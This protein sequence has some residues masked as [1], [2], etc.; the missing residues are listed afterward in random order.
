MPAIDSS[1]GKKANPLGSCS[2]R[3]LVSIGWAATIEP[4]EGVD[5]HRRAPDWGLRGWKKRFAA[6]LGAIRF[7]VLAW[8]YER[9]V[10]MTGGIEL[11]VLAALL[12]RKTSLVAA[13]WLIP[14]S[15]AL[16]ALPLLRRV[17][18]VVVRRNDIATLRRRF[19]VANTAFVP[20][21]APPTGDS[22]DG[23]YVY[24]GG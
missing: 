10:L 9:V 19:R 24:S 4:P 22:D 16:D 21:P 8:R 6:A 23:D 17:R 1:P 5:V 14:R 11:F 12:P 3:T 18:F 15:R 20:F 7:L 2:M 13:D